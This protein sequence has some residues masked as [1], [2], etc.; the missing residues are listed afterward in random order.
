MNN[1]ESQ[2]SSKLWSQMESQLY[3]RLG[4]RLYHPGVKQP[5]GQSVYRRINC[6]IDTQ[7]AIQLNTQ[8]DTRLAQLLYIEIK[9]QFSENADET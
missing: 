7:L 8:L 1:L 4:N 5:L 9:S 3:N 6:I 2:F